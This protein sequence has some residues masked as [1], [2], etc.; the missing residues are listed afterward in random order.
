MTLVSKLFV[1]S[2]SLV[3][4]V[5]AAGDPSSGFVAPQGSTYL[6][7]DGGASTTLYVKSGPAATDWSAVSAGGSTS[8][9]WNDVTSKPSGIVSSSTQVIYGNISGIPT[10]LLSSSAQVS[11]AGISGVPSGIVSASSQVVFSSISGRPTGLVSSSAQFSNTA[12]TWSAT[13]TFSTEPQFNAGGQTLRLGAT[14]GDH[15]YLALYARTTSPSTRTGWI[16]YGSAGTNDLS[17]TNEANGPINFSTNGTLRATMNSNGLSV[18]ANRYN[19]SSGNALVDASDGSYLALYDLSGNKAMQLGP[20]GDPSNYHNNTT[21]YFRNRAASA[22]YATINAGG[23]S[24]TANSYNNSSGNRILYQDG[25]YT[26]L[27]D[28][29]NNVVSYLAGADSYIDSNI[30]YFRN[31][32]GS[33]NHGYINSAGLTA[34]NFFYSSDRRLKTDVVSLTSASEKLSKLNGYTYTFLKNKETQYGVMADEV[35]KVLPHAVTLSEDGYKAVA[36]DRIIP[37][38]INA[39]NEQ[40]VQIQELQRAAEKPQ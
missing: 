34:I 33:T 4:V 35:E 32:G 12:I 22:F 24:V 14:S 27:Y 36:Y 5:T 7:T 6:R 11:F 30:L 39:I 31:A 18:A 29:S 2:D 13:Q 37:L 21:H 19:G 17:I 15:T 3:Q 8:V 1:S 28:V 10:G 26:R 23:I 38:L 20:S 25:T 16:G 40:R 9:A